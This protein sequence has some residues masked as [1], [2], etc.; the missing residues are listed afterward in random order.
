MGESLRI[1]TLVLDLD[2][3]L[4]PE[5]DY[6][7]S[8]FRA[9]D[10]WLRGRRA[11]EGFFAAAWTLFEAGRRG[12]IFDEAL[13]QLGVPEAAALVPQLVDVYRAHEPEIA[14]F[15]D[16]VALLD[17]AAGRHALAIIT[18]GHAAV[19]RR[20]LRALGLEARVPEIVVTDEL[21]RDCWK[22]HPA[23]FERVM[24]RFGG[25]PDGFIYVGD[26]PRKDFLAPK[27]LGWRT[28]RV[29][30]PGG[31]HGDYAATAAE[32]AEFS[33]GDLQ[34]LRVLLGGER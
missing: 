30:R 18:D 23:A 24:R 13:D 16:A 21:G 3:T 6:V 14:L 8:G 2:D 7:R 27:R 1:R 29:R 34:D 12:R 9:A 22:P 11:R 33:V 4:Y 10:G 17:W 19:Q 28:V 26:N 25:A 15:P 20:K 5:R 32:E 31:E